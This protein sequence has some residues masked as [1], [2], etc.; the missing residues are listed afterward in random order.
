MFCFL[1]EHFKIRTIMILG[2]ILIFLYSVFTHTYKFTTIDTHIK[3]RKNIQAFLCAC[4]FLTID[5]VFTF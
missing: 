2:S 3:K 1:T 4:S 5:I